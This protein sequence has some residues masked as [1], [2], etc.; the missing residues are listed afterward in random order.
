VSSAGTSSPLADPR[1]RFAP[2]SAS[3]PTAA[4]SKPVVFVSDDPT[5]DLQRARQRRTADPTLQRE[6]MNA[7]RLKSSSRCSRDR[8]P[9]RDPPGLWVLARSSPATSPAARVA[10]AGDGIIRWSF[11]VDWIRA[12][13]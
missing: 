10:T 8:G 5:Y 3:L 4:S 6:P 9:R 13:R 11:N 7:R 2:S 1:S 12:R